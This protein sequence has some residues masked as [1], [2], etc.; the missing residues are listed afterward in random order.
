M[1]KDEILKKITEKK[2]FSQLPKK[3]VERAFEKFEKRQCG[4]E[5]KIKLTRDLLRKVFSAFASQKILSLKNKNEEWILRKHL[6]TRERLDHYPELYKRIF[7]GFLDKKKI[8]F[9]L[10]AGINGFSY[11]FMPENTKYIG[12]EAIG[13]LVDLMNFY[14]KKEKLNAEAIHGSLFEIEKIKKIIQR[15]NGRKIVFLFKIIDSLEML[16]RDYSKK[17]LKEI[18]PLVERVVIS[19]ATRSMIK[20]EEFKANRSWIKKF[21]QENFKILDEFELGTEKYLVFKNK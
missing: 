5:E 21:I 7:R 9:D 20:R 17:F 11:K 18:T 14:F 4:D 2:E 10:G 13:Q 8:V 3:E 15:T 16:E 1:N 6:S 12:I 19:L